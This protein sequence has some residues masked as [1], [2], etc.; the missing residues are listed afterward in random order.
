VLILSHFAGA[1]AQLKEALLVNPYSAEDMADALT[2]A[3]VMPLDE[4]IDRWRTLMDSVRREDVMW[5]LHSFVSTLAGEDATPG[6]S[7]EHDVQ[8]SD[9]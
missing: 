2:A 9:S 7:R 5:W 1:A 3:L 8:T 4:R 6:E